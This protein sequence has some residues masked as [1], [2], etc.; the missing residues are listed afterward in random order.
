MSRQSLEV[1]EGGEEAAADDA[2]MPESEEAGLVGVKFKRGDQVEVASLLI[3]DRKMRSSFVSADGCFWE[4]DGGIYVPVGEDVLSRQIQR[5][6]GA[7]VEGQ[8]FGL[9]VHAGTVK[10]V[11]KLAADRVGDPEFFCRAPAGI[12]FADCFVEVT[13]KGIETREHSPDHRAR[14]KFDFDYKVSKPNRLLKYFRYAF[15]G[16]ADAREKVAFLQ[17]FLGISLLGKAPKYQKAALLHGLPGTAKSTLIEIMRRIFPKGSTCS[18]QPQQ[19]RTESEYW[20][21][22][23]AGKLLNA[24]PEVAETEISKS[25]GFKNAIS[26]EGMAARDPAGRPFVFEPTA[27]HILA[28]NKLP[29]ISNYADG[30]YRRLVL[31][32]YN[33]V[34]QASDVVHGLADIIIE[35]EAPAIVSWAL[36]GAQRLIKADAYTIPS[37][38][39]RYIE[40]WRAESDVAGSFVEA[41]G[42][43]K[44]DADAP[45]SDGLVATELHKVYCRWAE[46]CRHKKIVARNVF[47]EHMSRAGHKSK[48]DG[49]ARRYALRFP[50]PD[51]TAEEQ[52]TAIEREAAERRRP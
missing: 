19:L 51:E 31:I 13:A 25:E 16:D 2:P 38:S 9:K 44:L 36:R 18:I 22:T 52:P 46:E 24:V 10:G 49:N 11:L 35:E 6:A 17:E 33:R 45:A 1:I 27:G 48:S 28:A 40:R 26:G 41:F 34:V 32:K 21:A 8:P 12:G 37:S 7:P 30:T 23:L 3:R 39:S 20:R 50:K 14:F 43:V 5:Y 42:L 15:K 4:Y 47:G 29:V